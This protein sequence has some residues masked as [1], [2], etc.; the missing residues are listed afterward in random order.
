MGEMTIG[1]YLGSEGA[2]VIQTTELLLSARAIRDVLAA[3]AM[4]VLHG[5]AG[6]GK[7]FTAQLILTELA[8]AQG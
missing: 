8:V 6:S 7:T 1:H 5:P 2:R 4:G 3:R